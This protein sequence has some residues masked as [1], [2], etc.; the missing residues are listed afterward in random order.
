MWYLMLHGYDREYLEPYYVSHQLKNII[1]E[2]DIND[3]KNNNVDITNYF[4]VLVIRNPYYRL[5]SGFLH[6]V[7]LKKPKKIK[8]MPFVS[9]ETFVNYLYEQNFGKFK[10]TAS[11]NKNG[12]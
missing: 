2:N 1:S 12:T 6:N 11:L 10:D 9:F 4:K 3:C 5:I 8:K 7:C